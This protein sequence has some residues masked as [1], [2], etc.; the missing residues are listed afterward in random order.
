M[1][2][3]AEAEEMIARWAKLDPVKRRLLLALV[4]AMT[5]DER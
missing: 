2:L 3:I 5:E 1:A 4:R